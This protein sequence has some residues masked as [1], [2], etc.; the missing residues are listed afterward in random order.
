MNEPHNEYRVRF[1]ER[2]INTLGATIE[3]LY[4]DQAEGLKTIRQ[5][6]KKL[7]DG[8]K[9]SYVGIE[10]ALNRAYSDTEALRQDAASIKATQTEHTQRLERIES[11]Q[12]RQE[13]LLQVILDQ[14]TPKQ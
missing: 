2:Q 4:D 14:L 3:K 1:I 11:T 12:Q 9:A 10:D 5:E 6:I 8:I 13:L 7:D